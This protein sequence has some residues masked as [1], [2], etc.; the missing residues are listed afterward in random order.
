MKF[1]RIMVWST[2]FRVIPSKCSIN[3]PMRMYYFTVENS[4]S[5]KMLKES[6]REAINYWK[7]LDDLELL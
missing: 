6:S 5:K 1:M 2:F 7:N 3:Q 4:I